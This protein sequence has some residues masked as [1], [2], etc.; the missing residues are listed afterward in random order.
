VL[1]SF[2]TGLTEDEQAEILQDAT[3]DGACEVV[4]DKANPDHD[5]GCEVEPDGHCPHGC[6]S[7]LLV[8]GII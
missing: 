6:A 4:C 8:A 5:C 1:M 3:F 7:V 2:W